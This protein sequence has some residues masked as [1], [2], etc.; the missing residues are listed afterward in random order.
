MLLGPP[1]ILGALNLQPFQIGEPGERLREIPTRPRV[2]AAG[3]D[4]QSVILQI[5]S[6]HV[7]HRSYSTQ[8]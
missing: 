5:P 4:Q 6:A 8:P 7:T 3:R 2:A 1:S